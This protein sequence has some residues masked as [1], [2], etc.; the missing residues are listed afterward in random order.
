MCLG[1]R[2]P[3]ENPMVVYSGITNF[4]DD[5]DETHK[6]VA[7][8]GRGGDSTLRP[9]MLSMRYASVRVIFYH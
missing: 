3:S 5:P 8:D 2:R 6:K 7:E 9:S 4:T 1:R